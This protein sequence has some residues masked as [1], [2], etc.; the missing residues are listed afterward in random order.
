[1]TAGDRSGP[2]AAARLLVRLAPL[3][4]LKER[5]FWSYAM[6]PLAAGAAEMLILA[7]MHF[8]HP[9]QWALAAAQ[10]AARTL[11]LLLFVRLLDRTADRPFR[12]RVCPAA[13]ALCMA[14][15]TLVILAGT[16]GHHPWH[17]AAGKDAGRLA[18]LVFAVAAAVPIRDLASRAAGRPGVTTLFLVSLLPFADEWLSRPVWR[19]FRGG[20]AGLI[21]FLVEAQGWP[22]WAERYHDPRWGGAV[23]VRT[24]AWEVE[25]IRDCGDFRT[26]LY[27]VAL[28]A[29][30]MLSRPGRAANPG[31]VIVALLVGAAG[32]LSI[33]GWRMASLVAFASELIDACGRSPAVYRDIARFHNDG[34]P[35]LLYG[36]VAYFGLYLWACACWLDRKPKSRRTGV[37]GRSRRG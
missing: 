21:Q 7:T 13:L 8:Y 24:P 34:G 10:L 33:N 3:D 25:V 30:M 17:V 2:I 1:M 18:A 31:K 23:L 11:P 4:C 19:A 37:T 6:L 22:A 14:C 5:R 32:V 12:L 27:F 26:V 16:P 15:A 28:F 29:A 9:S 36:Y 20:L 35:W